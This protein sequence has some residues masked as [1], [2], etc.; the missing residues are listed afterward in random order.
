M[1]KRSTL[2]FCKEEGLPMEI[3]G[4]ALPETKNMTMSQLVQVIDKGDG[5]TDDEKSTMAL[6]NAGDILLVETGAGQAVK[7]DDEKFLL[8]DIGQVIGNVMRTR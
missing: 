5:V 4:I 1:R 3:G 2:L 7:I 8:I 6:I